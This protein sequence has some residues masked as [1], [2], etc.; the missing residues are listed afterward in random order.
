MPSSTVIVLRSNDIT[1]RIQ[2]KKRQTTY[3][4]VLLETAVFKGLNAIFKVH[5]VPEEIFLTT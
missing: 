3:T 4:T 1:F 2:H 5:A